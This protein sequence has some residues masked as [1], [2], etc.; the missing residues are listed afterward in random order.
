MEQEA[1]TTVEQILLGPKLMS[2]VE[3][4]YGVFSAPTR[5]FQDMVHAPRPMWGIVAYMLTTLVV[6][7]GA[8]ESFVTAGMSWTAFVVTNFVSSL[9]LWFISAASIHLF[10]EMLGGSGSSLGLLGLLGLACLPRL[11]ILPAQVASRFLGTPGLHSIVSVAVLVWVVALS[12]IAL[13]TNYGFSTGRA[14]AS[15][16]CLAIAIVT[17]IVGIGIMI[18]LV[19]LRD[20]AFQNLPWLFGGR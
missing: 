15:A 11:L 16:L 19:I 9:A 3:A 20:P 1:Q 4:V 2:P 10:A 6:S 13:K 5:T 18:V 8:T 14:I 7:L 17:I 12:I